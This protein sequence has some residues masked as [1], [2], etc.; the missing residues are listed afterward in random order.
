[1]LHVG[2][3][4]YYRWLDAKEQP[5]Y[6]DAVLSELEEIRSE[7]KNIG[8]WQ[9]QRRLK[10]THASYGTV[11]RLCR[12]NGLMAKRKPHSIT[13]ADKNAKPADDLVRRDFQ[14]DTPMTKL[15]NDITEMRCKDGKLYLAA[16]LDCF[17][18][19]IVGMS[20]ASNK[21]ATLCKE[22]LEAAV[23]RY[24]KTGGMIIHSDHGSQY[25]SNLFR[26]YLEKNHLRQSMGAVGSCFDN[27]RMES[28]FATFKKELIYTLPLTQLSCDEVKRVIFRWI[29]CNYNR[30]RPH[31]GNAGDLPPL[32]KRN[33]YYAKSQAA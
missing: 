10:R 8:V 29:E 19:A 18:G 32:E 14:A 17:D 31:S 27:A 25:T 3:P 7:Y 22:S 11:Y 20:M 12:A 26:D 6:R 9:M 4:G 15:L 5:H 1:M 21:R 24:G 13:K 23:H 30:L 2:R 33:A 16:T 28:F